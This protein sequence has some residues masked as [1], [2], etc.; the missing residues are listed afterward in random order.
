MASFGFM[1]YAISPAYSTSEK[2]KTEIKNAPHFCEA[3]LVG[4]EGFIS[5][6]Q[7]PRSI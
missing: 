7:K 5:T 4:V 3:F 6:Q 2:E 1:M